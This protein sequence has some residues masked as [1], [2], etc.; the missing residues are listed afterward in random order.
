ML[1]RRANH[2]F[3][4]AYKTS[5]KENWDKYKEAHRAFKRTL[6]KSKRE[7]YNTIQFIEQQQQTWQDFCSKIE[8]MHESA[9]LH[10][11]L[12]KTHVNELGMLRLPHGGWTK[13]LEEANEHPMDV[14]F[15]GCCI[16]KTT[17]NINASTT[18]PVNHRW[19]PSINWDIA[20]DIVTCER[21]KW[22][23]DCMSPFKSPGEDAALL[24]KGSTYLLNPIKCIYQASLALDY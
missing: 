15:P 18:Q 6:H 24:Q 1:R 5:T 8:T 13:S 10:K 7:S 3:H 11:L 23:F 12:G 4:R 9:R 19:I 14:H 16:D 21:N 2:A 17:K 20:S 22:A